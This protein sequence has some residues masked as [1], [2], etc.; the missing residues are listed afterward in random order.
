MSDQFVRKMNSNSLLTDM[1]NKISERRLKNIKVIESVVKTVL[2][3]GRQNL[4]LRG[5]RDDSQ[6]LETNRNVGNFQALL[7]FRV[8]SGDQVLEE[9]FQTAPRNATYRSKTIQNVIIDIIAK[10][11]QQCIVGEIEQTG[12]WYSLSADEV[13]DVANQEQLAVCLR[14]ADVNGI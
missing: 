1:N 4:P 8:D 12:G 13:Q 10:Q 5:A 6:Y 7:D 3:C 11:I 14:Y 9:H 2:L